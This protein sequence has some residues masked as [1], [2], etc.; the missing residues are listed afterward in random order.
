MFGLFAKN[1]F[2]E[3]LK[4]VEK[5]PHVI[6]QKNDSESDDKYLIIE[7]TTNQ[8]NF[9][10]TLPPNFKREIEL[11]FENENKNPTLIDCE[12]YKYKISKKSFLKKLLEKFYF[13]INQTK[14]KIYSIF[15]SKNTNDYPL[16]LLKVEVNSTGELI[17]ILLHENLFIIINSKTKGKSFLNK[18]RIHSFFS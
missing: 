14:K 11:N 1:D 10:D 13:K 2:T 3:E 12:F 6:Q 7:S 16:N 9:I 5:I 4:L 18:F 17:S 15:D 8:Y